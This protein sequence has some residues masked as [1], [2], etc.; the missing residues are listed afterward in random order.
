MTLATAVL[1]AARGAVPPAMLLVAHGTRDEAGLVEIARIAERVR[2][3][4]P[5]VRVSVA[6][7]DVLR[8]S[9]ADVLAEVSGPVVVVPLFLAAGYHVRHDVPAGVAGRPD[10]VVAP[11]MGPDRTLTGVLRERAASVARR[12]ER[13]VLAAAGSSDPRALGDVE[14]TAGWLS[15]EL[16]ESVQPAYLSAAS[17][18]VAD[19]VGPDSVIVPYLVA[20]GFFLR[21]AA[22]AGARATADVL[23]AHPTVI[24][25][26]AERYR[27]ALS[28]RAV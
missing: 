2:A 20:P 15:R 13:I 17:P 18:R 21:R 23:G 11:P 27:A 3:R 22:T 8:P 12:G 7:A 26:I 1:P 9:I 5:G 19:V 24:A 4:C 6:Y 25:V 16:G 28:A 14:R 10:V